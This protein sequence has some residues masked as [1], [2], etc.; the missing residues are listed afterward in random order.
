MVFPDDVF[1]ISI[2]SANFDGDDVS[3]LGRR[4]DRHLVLSVLF[5]GIE[6]NRVFL[7]LEPRA[8]SQLVKQQLLL[9]LKLDE[10]KEE[11]EGLEAV[12]DP[13]RFGATRQES[14]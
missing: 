5:K 14:N 3:E 12:G 4:T 13:P 8:K 9:L 11:L 10:G 1:A 7:H 2:K 6:R